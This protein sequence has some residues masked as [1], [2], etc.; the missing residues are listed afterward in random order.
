[1]NV[2]D[3]PLRGVVGVFEPAYLHSTYR[4]HQTGIRRYLRAIHGHRAHTTQ[5]L[6]G[7]FPRLLV[8][9][10]RK[11]KGPYDTLPRDSLRCGQRAGEQVSL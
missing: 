9:R 1:V 10:Q 5:A 7:P 8:V 2:L 3:I 4:H 6:H 11:T